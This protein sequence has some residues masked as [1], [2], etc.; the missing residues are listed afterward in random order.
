MSL[1][2]KYKVGD[3]V[4]VKPNS[5]GYAGAFAGKICEIMQ[6]DI[7][8]PVAPYRIAPVDSGSLG[9]WASESWLEPAATVLQPGD[10]CYCIEPGHPA[11]GM[12]VIVN[13]PY[14][15]D[16]TRLAV[17]VAPSGSVYHCDPKYLVPAPQPQ[18][19]SPGPQSTKPCPDCAH[20]SHP[21]QYIGFSGVPEPC[22]TCRG[23]KVVACVAPIGVVL[24]ARGNQTVIRLTNDNAMALLSGGSKVRFAADCCP[25]ILRGKVG[26][27][28]AIRD[29]RQ[30]TAHKCVYVDTSWP[31]GSQG[32]G[33]VVE[34]FELVTDDTAETTCRTWPVDPSDPLKVGDKVQAAFY[35]DTSIYGTISALDMDGDPVITVEYDDSDEDKFY[36]GDSAQMFAS[37]CVRWNGIAP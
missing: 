5:R 6:V 34:K 27:V 10:R 18:G 8:D 28:D 19:A 23:A 24:Q 3:R 29:R 12:L 13:G 9:A 4:I 14:A 15:F 33:H 2:P 37:Q 32:H 1:V 16:A 30:E 25:P 20:T 26:T 17:E 36:P 7:P 35:D 22:G 31:G 11:K 21:G